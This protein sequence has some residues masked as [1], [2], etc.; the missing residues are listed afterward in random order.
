[1]VQWLCTVQT[2]MMSQNDRPGQNGS[3]QSFTTFHCRVGWSA[4]WLT[5]LLTD[6]QL[7]QKGRDESAGESPSWFG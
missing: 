7:T 1:M 3:A 5:Q 4:Y 2:H 6:K